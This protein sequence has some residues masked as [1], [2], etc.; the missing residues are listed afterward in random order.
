M[1]LL[2]GISCLELFHGRK[3]R[4]LNLQIAIIDV[5]LMTSDSKPGSSGLSRAFQKSHPCGLM[6]AGGDS[7]GNL[8]LWCY[9]FSAQ[10]HPL[11][12]EYSQFLAKG[13]KVHPLN[14]GSFKACLFVRQRRRRGER[15]WDPLSAESSPDSCRAEYSRSPTWASEPSCV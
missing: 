12:W 4:Q 7:W 9:A 15:T 6:G 13:M 8:L 1:C 11:E 2:G 5:V 10:E 3:V 14:L